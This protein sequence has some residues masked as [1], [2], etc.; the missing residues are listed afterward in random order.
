M[1]RHYSRRSPMGLLVRWTL[2]FG[3]LYVALS[4]VAW[5]FTEVLPTLAP[6]TVVGGLGAFVAWLVGHVGAGAG[7]AR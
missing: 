7:G 4:A 1:S 5:L 3:L 6:A 2:F